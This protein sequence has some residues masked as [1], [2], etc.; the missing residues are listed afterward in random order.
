MRNEHGSGGEARQSGQPLPPPWREML[1]EVPSIRQVFHALRR[2]GEGEDAT[3]LLGFAARQEWMADL[4]RTAQTVARL[5]DTVLCE[6]GHEDLQ[7]TLWELYA[8]SRV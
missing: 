6:P 7:E 4:A 8:A 1:E 3:G 2:L 5:D